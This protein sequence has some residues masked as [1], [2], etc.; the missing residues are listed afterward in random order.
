MCNDVKSEVIS[1]L[2]VRVCIY[3][4]TLILNDAKYN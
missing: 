1:Y 3:S 4:F 2:S